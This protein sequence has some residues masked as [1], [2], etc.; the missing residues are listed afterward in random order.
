[1]NCDDQVTQFDI[2]YCANEAYVE[3]DAALNAHPDLYEKTPKGAQLAVREGHLDIASLQVPGL[4]CAL[5]P[6][7]GKRIAPADWTFAMLNARPA[8]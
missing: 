1:M 6:D 2:N 8:D 5:T 3:A 4:G 7:L